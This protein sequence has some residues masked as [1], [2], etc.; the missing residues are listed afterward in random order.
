MITILQVAEVLIKHGANVNTKDLNGDTPL[1][2]ALLYHNTDNI[3]ILLEGER[4]EGKSMTPREASLGKDFSLPF[5]SATPSSLSQT[6]EMLSEVTVPIKGPH[7]A[8]RTTEK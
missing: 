5:L 3:R 8:S 7:L 4:L 2:S 6:L 1:H